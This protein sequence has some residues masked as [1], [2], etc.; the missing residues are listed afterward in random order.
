MYG[1]EV[2]GTGLLNQQG[3]KSLT[4]SN[5]VTSANLAGRDPR[6][7]THI[8]GTLV[9]TLR[10]TTA[11]SRA[12]AYHACL[13]VS[14]VSYIHIRPWTPGGKYGSRG[15]PGMGLASRWFKPISSHQGESPKALGIAYIILHKFRARVPMERGLTFTHRRLFRHSLSSV[16]MTAG[17]D[18]RQPGKTGSAL[19]QLLVLAPG[20]AY[21]PV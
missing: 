3:R 4:G 5:P 13:G 16:L 6:H 11:K 20:R 18:R 1:R 19:D 12:Y 21:K 14:D 17:K 15:C 9:A 7:G 8:V 2:E 10:D